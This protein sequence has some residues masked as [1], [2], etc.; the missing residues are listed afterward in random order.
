MEVDEDEPPLLVADNEAQDGTGAV[1]AE[2]GDIALAKVPITIVTGRKFPFV[3]SMLCF[4]FRPSLPFV[5]KIHK[6]L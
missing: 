3:R 6:A 4:S 5:E 1:S 2:M